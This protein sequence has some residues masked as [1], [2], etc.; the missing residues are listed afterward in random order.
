MFKGRFLPY[1]NI[2]RRTCFIL[3]SSEIGLAPT[4]IINMQILEK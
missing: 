2:S 4:N 3:V 1:V